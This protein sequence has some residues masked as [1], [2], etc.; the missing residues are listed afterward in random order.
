M[1]STNTEDAIQKAEKTKEA[2]ENTI[3]IAIQ[4]SDRLSHLTVASQTLTED[5][6]IFKK[7][8]KDVK[9]K[10]RNEYAKALAIY[11][12]VVIVVMLFVGLVIWNTLF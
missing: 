1:A 5:A 6:D 4:R 3:Q 8:T 11:I 7:K 12:F 2:M 9:I 10:K